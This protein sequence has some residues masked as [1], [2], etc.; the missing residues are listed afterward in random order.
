MKNVFFNKKLVC[1]RRCVLYERAG[2]WFLHEES[3]RNIKMILTQQAITLRGQINTNTNVYTH[4]RYISMC[5]H[6]CST[7]WG[8]VMIRPVLTHESKLQR[9]RRDITSI[10]YLQQNM[11]THDRCFT[12]L[13]KSFLQ[14][15]F[16]GM[17]F[18]WNSLETPGNFTFYK[19]Q[20]NCIMQRKKVI[21]SITRWWRKAF[22]WDVL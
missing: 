18:S 2:L 22:F 11:I 6:I 8:D 21:R 10:Q 15:H 1:V 20:L 14:V 17:P 7:L 9:L 4:S 16:L 3:A 12:L 13:S 5:T 19:A